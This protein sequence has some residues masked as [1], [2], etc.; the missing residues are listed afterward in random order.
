MSLSPGSRLGSCEVTALIGQGGM[1][2]VYRARDT[3]LSSHG[4]MNSRAHVGTLA[5]VVFLSML[6]GGGST[7]RA[8]GTGRAGDVTGSLILDVPTG[9]AAGTLTASAQAQ[10]EADVPTLA[11]VLAAA[12]QYVTEFR[13]RLSGI[14]AEE[15]YR[16]RASTRTSAGG[17]GTSQVQRRELRSDFLLVQPEGADRLVEYRDVFEVDG[18]PVR[19]RQERLAR[20]FLNSSRSALSQMDAI[21]I[22]SARY[23]IGAITRTLNTPT[24]ALILLHPDIQPHVT[25]SRSTDR[26]PSLDLQMEEPG[27]STDVWV[28]EFAEH[29]AQT[30]VHGPR[31]TFLPAEGRFWIEA[32]SGV[33]VASELIV[34]A[35]NVSALIDVRYV[36][37][38]DVGVRVPDEM[39]GRYRD[40]AGDR[41]EG[42]ATYGNVRRFLVQ[43][44]ESFRD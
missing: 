8:G 16:Q 30:L 37:D 28:V 5:L 11:S 42:T 6:A 14:V 3:K 15:R 44:E 29:G 2:E 25:F 38:P 1:G 19:D 23:N 34:E 32:T 17:F 7:L 41:V 27:H 24:I 9:A 20:L 18:R 10:Q 39:R 21:T 33:V 13:D 31:G 4:N 36:L 35:P 40:R 26:T 22:E 12:G 43:A